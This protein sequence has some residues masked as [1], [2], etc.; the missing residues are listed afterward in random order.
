M[1]NFMEIMIIFQRTQ[2]MHRMATVKLITLPVQ[3]NCY[4]FLCMWMG[5][6]TD[7][8]IY[9]ILTEHA[10][11]QGYRWQG[12]AR[13]AV[14][15][16]ILSDPDPHT[17]VIMLLSHQGFKFRVINEVELWDEV[18]VV[19]VASIDV[20]LCTHAADAVKVMDVNVHKHPEETAQD[21]LAHLM[22]VLGE[23]YT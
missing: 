19:F 15:R 13:L 18:V 14:I 12:S 17:S 16:V 6:H 5:K 2:L 23:R 1:E 8:K 4:N 20:G 11:Q 21:L 10:A 22:E 9:L 7:M 3:Q